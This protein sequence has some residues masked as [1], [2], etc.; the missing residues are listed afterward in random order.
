MAKSLQ[1]QKLQGRKLKL[2][3]PQDGLRNIENKRK[4]GMR[5]LQNK[6]GGYTAKDISN[7]IRSFKKR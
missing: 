5:T 3:T 1:G 6:Q 4:S 2:Q 7:K